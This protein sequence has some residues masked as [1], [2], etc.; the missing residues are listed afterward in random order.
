M[1]QPHFWDR[2]EVIQLQVENKT[3]YRSWFCV[4][5]N[6]EKLEDFTDLSP[7][8]CVDKA[9]EMWCAGKPKRTCAVNYEIGDSG[10]PHMHMVLEDPAKARFTALQKLF[11]GIH[12]EPT[13]GNKEQASDYINKVG[14][15]EEKNH[16][17]LVPAKFRGEI[18]AQQGVRSDLQ[19][20][21]EMIDQGMTPNEIMDL[22]IENRK[23]ESIIRKAFFAKRSKEVP[24]KRDVNV[25]WHTGESGSGKSYTYV[26][27]CE[28]YGEDQVYL[29]TDYD[30]GG[31]DLYCAEP[32]IVLDE[33]KGS[34]KFQIFLNYLEGYK[35]QIH[36]RY[37][38]ARALW[39]EVHVT[40]I[41]PPDEVYN[42]MVEPEKRDRDKITQLM[43]RINTIVYHYKDDDGSYKQISIPASEY[44]NYD[45]L[46]SL[47][48]R[49][50][51][52]FIPVE[53]KTP[54]DEATQTKIKGL[55]TDKDGFIIVNPDQI[56]LPLE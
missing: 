32:Y 7:E 41:Y 30:V 39:N 17:I 16:T 22:N 25:I 20:I 55:E 5:N 21:Q 45:H 23:Y 13:R 33:F 35:I 3:A 46:K 19:A 51:A 34:L 53:E 50:G 42:F 29:M 14:K 1:G 52:G 56:T 12:I 49:I 37:A 9:I 8:Q 27:L 11:S 24:P 54:F 44:K 15:F 26:Q 36:C 28:E 47:R 43:R 48:Y 4:L 38:N 6:P 31:L 2:K 40:S 18:K 10:T